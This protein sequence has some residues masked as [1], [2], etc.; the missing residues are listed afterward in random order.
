LTAL[1]REA[2]PPNLYRLAMHAT[3]DVVRLV[4]EML[5]KQ[6]LRRP[7][8]PRELAERLVALEIATFSQR[9]MA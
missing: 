9:A 7:Q 6:P 1:H 4:G 8:T 3:V 2:T 5:A